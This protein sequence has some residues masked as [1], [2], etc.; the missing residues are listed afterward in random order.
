MAAG[1]TTHKPRA[2]SLWLLVRR[3]LCRGSKPHR[4]TSG[5]AAG[6]GGDD[7][8]EKSSLLGRSGSLEELLGSDGAGIHAS[9]K[10]DVQHVLLPDHRQRQPA[11]VARPEATLAVSSSA[12]AGG[13]AMQQYRRFVFGGFRRRLMMRRQWRPML[14]AIPE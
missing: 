10:K 4:T 11:D 9:V 2:K 13:A 3:M 1:S 7:G 14:V 12:R 6:D 5:A 8:G